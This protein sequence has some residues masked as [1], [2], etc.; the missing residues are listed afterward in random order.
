VHKQRIG[1]H[2]DGRTLTF[3]LPTVQFAL[4]RCIFD[5]IFVT[6]TNMKWYPHEGCVHTLRVDTSIIFCDVKHT[7]T[8]Y[9]LDRF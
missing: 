1:W 6:Y 8:Q 2:L 7:P 5:V 3:T 4:F 9:N